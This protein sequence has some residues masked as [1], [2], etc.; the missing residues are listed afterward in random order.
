MDLTDPVTRQPLPEDA[1]Q[2]IL[3][4]C[5][6]VH[7]YRIPPLASMA[8]HAAAS[9]TADPSRDI[10]KANLRVVETSFESPATDGG[11]GQSM[12]RV[13]LV[14]EDP[15]TGEVFAAAPYTHGSV[16]EPVVDS[17][18]Y[19]ALT[20]RDPQG[21]K[22]VIGIGFEDRSEASELCIVLQTARRGLGL[23]DAGARK[24]EAR[25]E[26][27]DYRLK[28]GQTI[29]VNFGSKSAT[30]RR[31]HESPGTSDPA[32]LQS[33]ALPPPPSTA[34]ALDGSQQ[35]G[36]GFSLPPPPSAQDVKRKRQSLRDLG[37]DDGKFGEFA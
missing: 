19:F 4:T 33:F 18:R 31:L 11:Q 23:E 1:I 20:V 35:P 3:F 2:R 25:Q 22:A 6:N 27:K 32:A 13:D 7:V 37:F 21:R 5:R 36:G 16:V 9:W 29:T 14:L 12:L 17:A 26:E 24:S 10:F 30:R 34:S 15:S 28:E 8:G